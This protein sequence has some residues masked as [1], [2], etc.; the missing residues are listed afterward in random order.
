MQIAIKE[1]T[2][3]IMAVIEYKGPAENIRTVQIELR[4]NGLALQQPT[5]DWKSKG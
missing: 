1:A 5:I 2:S 4:T 3:A